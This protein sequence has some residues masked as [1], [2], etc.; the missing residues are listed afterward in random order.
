M[1]MSG[2]TAEVQIIILTLIWLLRDKTQK[3]INS[4]DKCQGTGAKNKKLFEDISFFFTIAPTR[5]LP[6]PTFYWMPH[7]ID[8]VG[9]WPCAVTL[10]AILL[11]PSWWHFALQLVLTAAIH[12]SKALNR[13]TISITA[14]DCQSFPNTVGKAQSLNW[15]ES[16]M[17]THRYR[18]SWD[19]AGQFPLSAARARDIGD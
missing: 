8:G 5:S 4:R 13:D 3:V 9:R 2:S 16:Y 18:P 12:L 1:R 15:R 11:L 17:N 10:L 7:V 14:K 6:W 19:L